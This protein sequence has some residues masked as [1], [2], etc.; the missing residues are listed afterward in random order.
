[1]INRKIKGFKFDKFSNKQKII[2]TWW[3]KKS[4]Y[5]DKDMI[6]CDG[7][8]R[9]GKTVSMSISYIFWAMENFE[10]E[11]FFFAGKTISSLLRNVIIPLKNILKTR[12]YTVKHLRTDN[13][14]IIFKNGKTNIFYLFGGKDESSQ[15]LIQGL[16][17]AGGF[18]DEVALMPRSFVDQAVARCSVRFSRIWFNCNPSS[19][20]HWFKKEFIDDADRKNAVRIHF[21]MR[22]NLSLSD[23]IIKRY[24]NLYSG[25]FY[26]RYILGKWVMADGIIFDMFGD[27]NKIKKEEL[28]FLDYEEFYI[29]I[30]YGTQNPCVFLLWGKY[31]DVWYCIK[32]YYYN[33]RQEEKQKTDYEYGK[34]LIEFTNSF[35]YNMN[36]K[37]IVD[38]S[39]TSFKTQ[40]KQMGVNV[41]NAKNEVI[42]GIR[43]TQNLLSS[44][45]IMFSN[46]L[47]NTFR[48]FG[49]Y[50]WDV[51]KAD[52]G[53]DEPLKTNDH[54]MDSVRYFCYTVINDKN[55]M[56][57]FDIKDLGI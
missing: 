49:S 12:G 47:E 19:P 16:T 43:V 41:I 55:K 28:L 34:D 30:D 35:R 14:L 11:Q 20:H 50:A 21:T 54:A 42:D 27:E 37:A 29:S 15:D 56:K 31:K 40:L 1:M 22:D 36:Y 46:D 9:A 6:I 24:E 7:S 26:Q 10:N 57:S 38:P 18:F 2:L 3:N 17:S 53:K 23:D 39:A 45:K 13:Q 25:V 8:V 33:G 4:P 51:K 48:E 52:S 44:K 32:E 5:Y